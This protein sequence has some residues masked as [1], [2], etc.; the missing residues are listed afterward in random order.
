MHV[1][2]LVGV[3]EGSPTRPRAAADAGVIAM[4]PDDGLHE[5]DIRLGHASTSP[6]RESV[7]NVGV[8][9]LPNYLSGRLS[10]DGPVQLVLHRA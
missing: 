9:S 3:V 7:R 4:H 2:L 6:R 5:H 10:G 8:H 1:T